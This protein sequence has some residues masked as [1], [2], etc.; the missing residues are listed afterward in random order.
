MGEHK[1]REGDPVFECGQ[2]KEKHRPYVN[3]ER[4]ETRLL[5]VAIFNSVEKINESTLI[6]RE[7]MC[8]PACAAAYLS[9]K[10]R[11]LYVRDVKNLSFQMG[12]LVVVDKPP[13][14]VTTGHA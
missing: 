14:G 5:Y 10:L 11:E 12:P 8:G 3:E 2:C 9:A 6:A 7:A 13:P 4:M 1:R